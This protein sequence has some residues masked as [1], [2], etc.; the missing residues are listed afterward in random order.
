MILNDFAQNLLGK[1][2]N[3]VSNQNNQNTK[4][5]AINN[6]VNS[7]DTKATAAATDAAS[8]KS[9][10]ST[11]NT[12]VNTANT[13]LSTINANA[14]TAAEKTTTIASDMA[15]IKT[16]IN[17]INTNTNTINTNTNTILNKVNNLSTGGIKSIQSGL[18]SYVSS[19]AFP[20]TTNLVFKS[21]NRQPYE[22]ITIG[23]VNKNKCI[24]NIYTNASIAG[25]T[26][27]YPVCGVLTSSTTLVIYLDSTTNFSGTTQT[28]NRY[29]YR[30]EVIE[31]Y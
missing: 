3:I 17:T 27:M 19:Q 21:G 5:D 26:I 9:T 8:I 18:V 22:E 7:V 4:L 16:A 14:S 6:N 25:G 1:L 30:W 12:N 2:N 31:Y 24:V 11:I 15:T 20:T 13:T 10:V 28:G 23:S 29:G